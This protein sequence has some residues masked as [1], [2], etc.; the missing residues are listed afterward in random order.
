MQDNHF[1][2]ALHLATENDSFQ[3]V[4]FLLKQGAD[5]TLKNHKQL[6]PFQLCYSQEMQ[7]VF[8]ELDAVNNSDHQKYERLVV[9]GR[10]QKNNRVDHVNKL[11]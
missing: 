8:S 11:L 10:L 1:N 5:F 2:T 6:T 3:T 9:G 4:E 7:M